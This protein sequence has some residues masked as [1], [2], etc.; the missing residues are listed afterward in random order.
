MRIIT[1]IDNGQFIESTIKRTENYT[2]VPKT[3][4]P[5]FCYLLD[6]ED[7][8]SV[9]TTV[10]QVYFNPTAKEAIK[11]EQWSRLLDFSCCRIRVTHH[12][13]PLNEHIP[14]SDIKFSEKAINTLSSN[15]WVCGNH[16]KASL[17]PHILKAPCHKCGKEMCLKHK[18]VIPYFDELLRSLSMEFDKVEN[19][20]VLVPKYG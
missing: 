7:E 10:Y 2:I 13:Q 16:N 5:I 4:M 19:D 3:I 20:T 15:F 1:T 6:V 9:K 17:S 12:L 8:P 11:K 14:H 18:A